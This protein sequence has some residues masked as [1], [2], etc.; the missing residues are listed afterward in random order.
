MG[1]TRSRRRQEN[2]SASRGRRTGSRPLASDESVASARTPLT[3]TDNK[4][5]P[6]TPLRVSVGLGSSPRASHDWRGPQLIRYPLGPK[7]QCPLA[8]PPASTTDAA[9]P[10]SRPTDD[11]LLPTLHAPFPRTPRLPSPTSLAPRPLPPSTERPDLLTVSPPPVVLLLASQ[12]P[13]PPKDPSLPS[14]AKTALA[15]FPDATLHKPPLYP[16]LTLFPS[17]LS[18]RDP[19]GPPGVPNPAPASGTGRRTPRSSP[20]AGLSGP[21]RPSTRPLTLLSLRVPCTPLR[22]HSSSPP[23]PDRSRA[24]PACLGAP[25]SS[26]LPPPPALDGPS[27]PSRAADLKELKQNFC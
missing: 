3:K 27:A 17:F 14:F 24:N 4:S 15:D 22:P 13:P 5:I 10:Y 9:H 1:E 11:D 19:S 12:T 18:S 25:R 2:A 26:P 6:S 21:S 23:A 8:R 20:G 7:K 16:R